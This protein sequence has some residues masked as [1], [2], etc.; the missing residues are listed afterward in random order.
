MYITININH[1]VP[2]PN[3]LQL[4]R[5]A[6]RTKAIQKVKPKPISKEQILQKKVRHRPVLLTEVVDIFQKTFQT[7]KNISKVIVD[8]TFGNGGHTEAILNQ[9]DN[10]VVYGIDRDKYKLFIV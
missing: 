1:S 8:G 6:I 2:E 7:H 3:F 5:M 10:S 9:I 4:E